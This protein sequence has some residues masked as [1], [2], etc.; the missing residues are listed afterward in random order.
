MDILQD[1]FFRD[2]RESSQPG[3]V[4]RKHENLKQ[5]LRQLGSVAIAFSGGV[6]STFLLK[7]AHDALGERAIAVTARSCS[8]PLREL[9]E[10][11]AFCE[12]ENILHI[13]C[14]SEE[15]N[16]EGFSKNPTN[17]CYLCKNELFTKIW[18]VAREHGIDNVAEG[19]NMDDN[20]DY[21]PG[22]IAV[23]EQGVK[24][25]LRH[26]EL[27]KSEIRVL[28]KEMGLPTWDKQSFACLS[29]RFPYGESITEE[30]L[31]MVDQAEQVLLDMGLK[32]VRVRH[33]GNL[34]RIETDEE[35]FG[36]FADREVRE[37]LYD[38]FKKIGFTYVSLDLLGYRTGS[39]NETLVL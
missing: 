32:Q 13:V 29:S 2:G 22:L 25:P 1:T 28:S 39:M 9:K 4:H 19:S 17:R 11:T 24:S 14:D 21:R 33:H 31:R 27:F 7:T 36:A 10:A 6:D 18:S 26:A 8:F 37:A 3:D 12:K 30:R 20:G 34:A 35:G 15:L 16:I 5:Y 38:Q 23:R